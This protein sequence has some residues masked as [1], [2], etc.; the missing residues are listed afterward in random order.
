MSRTA[1]SRILLPAL[2]ALLVPAC[3]DDDDDGAR[4]TPPSRGPTE[5]RAVLRGGQESPPVASPGAGTAEVRVDA[6]R[7]SIAF[8]LT[9]ENLTG[10]AGAHIHAGAPGTHGPIV[11][12][13]AS[14]SFA[15]P[16]SG[17]LTAGDLMPAPAHGINTFADAAEAILEGRT[18]VNVHT[19]AHPDGEIR[20]HLGPIVLRASLDGNQEVPPV[21]TGG[22]GTAMLDVNGGQRQIVVTLSNSGLTGPP[23]AAHLHVG[24]SGI[25]GPII[26]NLA[27][28]SYASP[29]TVI[30]TSI[31]VVPQ[32]AQ[33][34]NT[35]DDAIN[36][37]LSGNAYVNVHTTAY[38]DG[39]IRGQVTP[40]T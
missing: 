16:H 38:P 34:I 17:V 14:A 9:V 27:T 8:T 37:L 31:H 35:F 39:E 23:M 13:L 12:V 3:H 6:A 33:G 22:S 18:Y 24:A 10:L 1:A 4:G 32:P 7:T 28:T 30:L 40:R 2:A 11:F 25:E 15:S 29:L 26:F 5:R 19:T 36:A 20:G 21:V